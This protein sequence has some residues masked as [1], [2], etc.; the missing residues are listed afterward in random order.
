MLKNKQSKIK[1]TL[2]KKLYLRVC[3]KYLIKVHKELSYHL[4]KYSINKMKSKGVIMVKKHKELRFKSISSLYLSY[5]SRS[6]GNIIQ[7]GKAVLYYWSTVA[8][9]EKLRKIPKNIIKLN[10]LSSCCRM[11]KKKENQIFRLQYVLSFFKL[12]ALRKK[13]KDKR[14]KGRE[15]ALLFLRERLNRITLS[16]LLKLRLYSKEN[17]LAEQDKEIQMIR[18]QLNDIFVYQS[19]FRSKVLLFQK[20]IKQYLNN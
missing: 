6:K 8:K 12:I 14:F 19:S 13:D 15:I 9:Y 20:N 1:L 10:K 4:L 2:T 3:I 5:F 18:L 17:A 16:Y 7:Q 11:I